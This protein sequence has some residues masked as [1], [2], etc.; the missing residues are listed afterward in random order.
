MVE[1]ETDAQDQVAQASL[2]AVLP[3]TRQ[4]TAP[5]PKPRMTLSGTSSISGTL[6]L[7]KGHKGDEKDG[8]V[9][10]G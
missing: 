9:L 6:L 2:S 10:R 1:T 5:L 7:G 4:H 8:T 3:E